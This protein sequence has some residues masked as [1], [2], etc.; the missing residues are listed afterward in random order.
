M[1]WISVKDRLPKKNEEILAYR[2]Q[3]G[4][5]E[6]IISYLSWT[7]SGEPIWADEVSNYTH[8][9]PLPKPPEKDA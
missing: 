1:E 2:F 6:I 3:D 7:L 5:H 4:I 8:W 9:M